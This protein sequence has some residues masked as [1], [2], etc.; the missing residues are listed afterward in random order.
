MRTKDYCPNCQKQTNHKRLF[1]TQKQSE[2]E[3][4]FQWEENYEIIE[5]LGCENFQFRIRSADEDMIHYD[6]E[7]HMERYDESTYFPRTVANHERLRDLYELPDKLRIVYIETIEA[8]RN[9]CYLLSG[10][11]LRAII[12]AFCLDQKI[13][14][15][16]LEKRLY[17]LVRNKL[18]TEKDGNRLHSIRFLGNDS[19][20]EMDVPSE[21]KIRIALDIVEHLIRNFYL[22]DK[23]ANKYLDTIIYDYEQFKILVLRKFKMK[24][25][26]DGD[27]KNIQEI[28]G[29]DFRRI[30]K[31]Y[32]QNFI[33]EF[34]DEV[35]NKNLAYVSLGKTENNEQYFIKNP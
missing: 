35:N 16:N 4:E 24:E 12:E 21:K 27:E 28:L 5:C 32:I 6:N 8:L 18:I 29:K 1:G 26:K 9:N 10:V 13:P 20:H 23:E 30:E 33:Q 31:N 22:I 14:G 7:G 19:V 2:H 17:N 3:D 15:R 34:I 11:G 25:F